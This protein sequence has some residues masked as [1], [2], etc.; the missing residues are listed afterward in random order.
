MAYGAPSATSVAPHVWRH[1]A[2][3]TTIDRRDGSITE[4]NEAHI[5]KQGA[6][7]LLDLSQFASL[8]EAMA[9]V[10]PGDRHSGGSSCPATNALMALRRSVQTVVARKNSCNTP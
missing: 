6:P 9:K 7:K 1:N 3:E 4:E 2:D 10:E 5:A 8:D